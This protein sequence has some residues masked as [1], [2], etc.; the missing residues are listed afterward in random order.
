[1]RRTFLEFVQNKVGSSTH[2]TG[3]DDTSIDADSAPVSSKITLGDGNEF[4]PFVVS[5]DPNSQFYG[6]NAGV[7][8]LIRAFKKGGN[9]GWSKDEKS[10]EDKPVKMGGKK[11]FL[12]GGALRDHL[13]G[14]KARNMELVTNA[15]PDEI[16]HI[17]VQ[18]GFQFIGDEGAVNQ[19]P[20]SKLCFWVKR[21]DKRGRPYSFGIKIKHD[22]M[23]LSVFTKTMK[24]ENGKILE[25]GSHT[26]DAS[27]R[28]F[29]INAMYLLLSQDNGP[30][31]ELFDFYG[32]M[33]H[34]LD[35]RIAP[36]GNFQQKLKEDP[37]RALRYAR[38]LARYGNVKKIP[39]EERSALRASAEYLGRMKPEDL[40][41]EFMKGMNYEDIDPRMYLKIYNHLGLLGG[42]FPGMNLDTNFPKELRELGDKYAPIAWMLRIH[43]PED[44]QSRLSSIW[45]PSELKKILFFIKS[46]QKLDNNMDEESLEDLVQSYLQSGLSSRKLKLWASR[47]G[48]K[49]EAL[50]DAFLQ[51][52]HAPRVKIYSGGEE[53]P[54][55]AFADL[56]DPFNGQ[57]NNEAADQRK[58][59]MEWENFRRLLKPDA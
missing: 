13:F 24:G 19:A 59:R 16:Y 46:L 41:D 7:A 45:R 26:D 21:Q 58:R 14:K 48:G 51:H 57:M 23:E 29:T 28:D 1:M 15:S 18:N 38:M 31:K 30:N 47:L 11:L 50:V 25:P 8:A 12:T 5:D 37:I 22:E 34:L 4:P 49:P 3:T 56:V 54:T 6:K 20:Q 2:G 27:S 32:G 43:S 44:I 36:V 39:E 52:A 10:G 40:M 35:G 17:L 55:D 53:Q 42:L 33:R 9:W